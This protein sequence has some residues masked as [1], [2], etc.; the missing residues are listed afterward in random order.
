MYAWDVRRDERARVSGRDVVVIVVPAVRGRIDLCRIVESIVAARE[1]RSRRGAV[2]SSTQTR[3]RGDDFSTV[4]EG[5]AREDEERD[6]AR[7]RAGGESDDLG[8]I[9]C[10]RGDGHE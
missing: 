10:R 4:D 9:H 2:P 3:A 7:T 8:R 5:A 1:P 6:A